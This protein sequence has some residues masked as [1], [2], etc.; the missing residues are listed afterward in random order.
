MIAAILEIEGLA[1]DALR[2]IGGEN[3]LKIHLHIDDFLPKRVEGTLNWFGQLGVAVAIEFY[4]RIAI[5]LKIRGREVLAFVE[6][7]HQRVLKLLLEII[8]NLFILWSS[9]CV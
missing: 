1:D 9:I 6:I 5:A 8:F 2:D 3:V 7:K 4:H